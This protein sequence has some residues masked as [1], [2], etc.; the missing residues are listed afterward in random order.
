[1]RISKNG[2]SVHVE[3]GIWL[4]T[5]GSIHMTCNELRNFHIAVIPNQ[6]D[7]MGILLCIEGLQSA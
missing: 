4:D 1:M 3:I 6:R 5:D 7:A 2:K